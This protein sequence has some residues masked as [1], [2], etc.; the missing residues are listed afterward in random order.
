MEHIVIALRDAVERGLGWTKLKEITGTHANDF[1]IIINKGS[2]MTGLM[3]E[4]PTVLDFYHTHNHGR[5]Q[6]FTSGAPVGWQFE[7]NGEM[8]EVI[9]TKD[10]SGDGHM[11]DVSWWIAQKKNTADIIANLAQQLGTSDDERARLVHEITKTVARVRN[12]FHPYIPPPL[13]IKIGI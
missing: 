13:D 4:G 1:K 10:V 6:V 12:E 3:N 2:R 11:P 5:L 9:I 8:W 7:Q